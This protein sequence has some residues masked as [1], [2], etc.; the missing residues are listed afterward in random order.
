MD[1]SPLCSVSF[2]F[3]TMVI[4]S[5][6]IARRHCSPLGQDTSFSSMS[7]VLLLDGVMHSHGGVSA[8]SECL[9]QPLVTVGATQ[10][11][12]FIYTTTSQWHRVVPNSNGIGGR[13][14]QEGSKFVTTGGSVGDSANIPRWSFSPNQTPPRVKRQTPGSRATSCSKCRSNG[15]ILDNHVRAVFSPHPPLSTTVWTVRHLCWDVHVARGMSGGMNHVRPGHH[16][17][18]RTIRWETGHN[19]SQ[20][21]TSSDATKAA[22]SVNEGSPLSGWVGIGLHWS[23]LGSDTEIVHPGFGP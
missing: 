2:S 7:C 8:R 19:C 20:V 4:I 6:N 12:S 21:A 23:A 22:D 17:Q 1:I 3:N 9:P 10:S 14:G 15:V 16:I 11:T 13:M 5:T 18:H